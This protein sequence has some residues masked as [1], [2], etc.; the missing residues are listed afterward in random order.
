M[1]PSRW[2]TPS[3]RYTNEVNRLYGVMDRRLADRDFLADEYSIADM[4]SIGWVRSHE[5]QGQDL[6]EFPNLKRWFETLMAR[7]HGGKGLQHRHRV[8]QKH[9]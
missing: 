3:K 4:A 6:D 1:H 8:S 7:L 9:C 5:R 2:L